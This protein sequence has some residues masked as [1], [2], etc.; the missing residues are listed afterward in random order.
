MAGNVL[1]ASAAAFAAIFPQSPLISKVNLS[2]PLT[3]KAK[4]PICLQWRQLRPNVSRPPG[5]LAQVVVLEKHNRQLHYRSCY[6]PALHPIRAKICHLPTR[7]FRIPTRSQSAC[8]I[9]NGWSRL[10]WS[11]PHRTWTCGSGLGL[12]V[13]VV[14]MAVMFAG[15]S[16]RCC[17]MAPTS[18]R[19]GPTTAL[20][21]R[22]VF[23]THPAIRSTSAWSGSRCAE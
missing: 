14:G 10:D 8:H 20:V 7:D 23:S 4:S 9:A 17:G 2:H 11:R 13:V 19:C 1:A 6:E 12:L 5:P 15:Y 22:C 18:I 3:G 16:A 21:Y